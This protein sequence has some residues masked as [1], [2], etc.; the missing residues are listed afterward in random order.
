MVSSS[1]DGELVRAISSEPIS[2]TVTV[3]WELTGTLPSFDKTPRT[4]ANHLLPA[5]LICCPSNVSLLWWFDSILLFLDRSIVALV[6]KQYF[7]GVNGT[8]VD[9]TSTLTKRR[10]EMEDRS[11]SVIL[12]R[13]VMT[14]LSI[15]LQGVGIIEG[16]LTVRVDVVDNGTQQGSYLVN[17]EFEPIR[18]EPGKVVPLIVGVVYDYNNVGNWT[19]IRRHCNQGLP[20]T[21][22]VCFY[23]G[24]AFWLVCILGWEGYKVTVIRIPFLPNP[25]PSNLPTVV[26]GLVLEI[27][28]TLCEAHCRSV[29]HKHYDYGLPYAFGVRL[30]LEYIG[31][32][33]YHIYLLGI[34]IVAVMGTTVITF[35]P[36]MRG[37]VVWVQLNH[38]GRS[39]S[40]GGLQFWGTNTIVIIG[41][42][43]GYVGIG[44][45]FSATSLVFF[46]LFED[47]DKSLDAWKSR[48]LNDECFVDNFYTTHDLWHVGASYSLMIMILLN[49]HIGKP[50]RDC[51]L[52][53]LSQSERAGKAHISLSWRGEK[54]NLGARQKVYKVSEVLRVIRNKIS[55]QDG[56]AIEG[57]PDIEEI[58]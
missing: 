53:Y 22:D 13:N 52:S 1:C 23:L 43:I 25:E 24:Y 21:L 2:E 8:K 35:I 50:C 45:L 37:L 46:T 3:L 55:R 11:Q 4:W 18:L 54:L 7:P 5:L 29:G 57:V 30:V 12:D 56:V 44:V 28:Y 47:T 36:L 14:I 39:H 33:L 58:T 38:S 34:L 41:V 40:C 48:A 51:Y 10:I 19:K 17:M 27:Y 26:D 31:T 20:L 42:M 6:I 49:V 15:N 16:Y 9:F 32:L